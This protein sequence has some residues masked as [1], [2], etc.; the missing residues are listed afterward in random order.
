M[1]EAE[2]RA[3]RHEE[4]FRIVIGIAAAAAAAVIAAA[5]Q[6]KSWVFPGGLCQS[7]SDRATEPRPRPRPPR[8]V[9]AARGRRREK[10]KGGR[11]SRSFDP[12]FSWKPE[13]FRAG[14]EGTRESGKGG[15]KRQQT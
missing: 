8:E 3:T 14:E 5:F 12:H 7:V 1:V 15:Q 4:R 9:R 10:V 11:S 2:V 13:P 6:D